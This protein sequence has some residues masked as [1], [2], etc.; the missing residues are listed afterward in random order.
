[1]LRPTSAR[2]AVA[3]L[4]A[5]AVLSGLTACGSDDGDSGG[6]GG[7]LEVW[8]RSA[9]A[10]AET[11]QK[12][13]DA[14]TEETGIEIDYKP[15][16]EFDTQI[17]G[18]A[19][20]RDL[21]DVFINDSGS[22]GTYQSQGWLTPVDRDSVTGGEDIS[23]ENWAT[24]QGLDGDYYGIPFSRQAFV[25]VVRKDW[26]ENLGLPVPETWEDLSALA[27]AFATQDPDGNGQDDT[28]G[29]VV[30]G[31]TERGYLAWWASSYIWQG[32]GD[33]VTE[34]DDGTY[35]SA[36][37]SP[38]TVAAVE[39]IKEQFCTPGHV[40]PN[41]LT[42]T[43]LESRQF[44]NGE[45]GIYLTGPYNLAAYDDQPGQ[46]TYEVIP[47]PPGPE[48]TTMLA[49][50]ENIYLGAGSDKTD[51][52]LKLA[53]FLI[54]PEAQ[55]IAMAA[56]EASEPVVRLPVNSTVDAGQVRNDP[57]WEL[58]QEQY[59]ND[60]RAFP[61]A[62]NFTPIRQAVAEGLNA[63]MADCGSDVEAGVAGISEDIDAELADQDLLP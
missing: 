20:S 39:W 42:S 43:T 48:G 61:S 18:R 27:D 15:V 35:E 12:V 50:G 33:F 2:T 28:F 32:G 31:T 59:D 41:A 49:E 14:F 3:L 24:T 40:Q 51:A 8:T 29:M 37:D 19:A 54:S 4:A 21:P 9:D 57:R 56:D 60:S 7:A 58:V 30:P 26:R 52:Q 10:P 5:G 1:M 17:Q 22:L 25:T 63:L 36:F 34:G 62:I 46:D 16:V 11:Y 38:G 13:F 45:A 44:N 53:E 55:E 23:D 47:T 6:S